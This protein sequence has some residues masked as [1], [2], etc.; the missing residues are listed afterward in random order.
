[1]IMESSEDRIKSAN[2][3]YT[4]AVEHLHEFRKLWRRYYDEY[5]GSNGMDFA[6]EVLK[7]SD[8]LGE[9]ETLCEKIHS[10]VTRHLEEKKGMV[11][12]S[13]IPRRKFK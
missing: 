5:G 3:L 9:F 10:R 6:H 13:G 4:S 12:V 8:H 2:E 7:V 1:M 11:N